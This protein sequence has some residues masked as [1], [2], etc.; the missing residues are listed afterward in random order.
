MRFGARRFVAGESAE[1]L[2]DAARRANA[3]G[4]AVAAGV[5]GE[6]TQTAG[7]A[8]AAT[9]QYEDLLDRFARDGIDANVAL[10]IT[11]LGL[12]V[13]S[14]LA[15][16]NVS[17]VASRAARFGNF[18]RLDMEQSRYVDATL[19]AYRELRKTLPNVGCALQSYLY[20]SFHDLQML[21]PLEPNVR[22]VKGA[23]LESPRIAYKE[24]RE[25]DENYVRMAELALR[26]HGFTAIATHDR[27]IVEHLIGFT[28]RLRL[29]KQGRFEFQMLYGVAT[30]Y[31]RSVVDRGYRLRLAI[32]FGDYWFPYLMRRLAERPA[33]L[34]FFVK[35]AFGERGASAG[36]RPSKD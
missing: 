29:P 1:D 8:A 6:G 23:Y 28:D 36:M 21:L 14:A 32:P 16:Q 35:G 10:K 5:L 34:V 22:L 3:D 9:R 4:F 7:D 33:N 31:A 27:R 24:K 18:M 25:V 20:R 11:H 26:G 13:D 30:G 19:G 15:F 12:N 2:L 17:A